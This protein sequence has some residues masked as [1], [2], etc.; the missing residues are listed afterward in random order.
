M[1]ADRQVP[2]CNGRRFLV[3]LGHTCWAE[4]HAGLRPCGQPCA[5]PKA[6]VTASPLPQPLGKQREHLQQAVRGT[7]RPCGGE[8]RAARRCGDPLKP[9]AELCCVRHAARH[10][11]G[12]LPSFTLACLLAGKAGPQ[13]CSRRGV[14]LSNPLS[15]RYLASSPPASTSRHSC[16]RSATTGRA[17]CRLG[18]LHSA[19]SLGSASMPGS[20]PCTT[21]IA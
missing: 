21:T 5:P 3:A 11:H 7:A 4:G 17:K 18:S 15:L 20:S 10:N 2:A 13:G 1:A 12:V 9:L 6:E 16:S 19:R 14:A 8:R